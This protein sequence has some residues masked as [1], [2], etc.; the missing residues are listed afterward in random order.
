MSAAHKGRKNTPE[1]N[2]NISKAI[3]GHPSYKKTGKACSES[4]KEKLRQAMTGRKYPTRKKP[5]AITEKHR[6]RLREGQQRR[7]A[8]EKTEYDPNSS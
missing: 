8:R 1:H 5:H 7:R 3:R 4:T 2:A 6:L